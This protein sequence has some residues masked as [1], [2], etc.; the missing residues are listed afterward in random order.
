MNDLVLA[1]LQANISVG[2]ITSNAALLLKAVK[3]GV[4]KYADLF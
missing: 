3:Q 2:S 1:D 4:Q